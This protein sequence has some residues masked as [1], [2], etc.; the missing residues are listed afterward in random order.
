MRGNDHHAFGVAN[1]D[2]ARPYRRIAAG[3]GTLMSSAWCT[4]RLVGAAGRL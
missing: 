4:V 1:D 2:I 3:I